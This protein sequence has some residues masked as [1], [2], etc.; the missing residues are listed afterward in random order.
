MGEFI[1][2]SCVLENRTIF[3]D[4]HVLPPALC[5]LLKMGELKRQA[6]YFNPQDWEQQSPLA[7]DDYYGEL[8]MSIEGT[9]PRYFQGPQPLGIAMTGGLDTRV[10][11][12][13]P[14]RTW[15]AAKLHIRGALA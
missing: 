11:L 2:L 1:A 8:R 10:I 3:K 13:P 4:I 12:A 15:D 7:P 14:F 9:L 5:G 6:T